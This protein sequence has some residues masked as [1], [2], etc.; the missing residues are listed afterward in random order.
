MSSC[1]T[2]KLVTN[3]MTIHFVTSCHHDVWG[4][5]T[6]TSSTS[7]SVKR[8]PSPDGD[9]SIAEWVGVFFGIVS[10]VNFLFLSWSNVKGELM[11]DDDV[12]ASWRLLDSKWKQGRIQSWTMWPL[13]A[14]R[15]SYCVGV[16]LYCH[17]LQRV[18]CFKFYF[19]LL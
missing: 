10:L 11:C 17:K 13:W 12:W 7:S 9:E 5:V 18:F 16:D 6:W 3:E 4:G 2:D 19:E 14:V 8:K 15:W 1:K